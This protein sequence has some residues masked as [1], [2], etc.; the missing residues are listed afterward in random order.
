MSIFCSVKRAAVYS[1]AAL[2]LW[3]AGTL[4]QAEVQES[5]DYLYYEIADPAETGKSLKH[6]LD[7]ATPV[8]KQGVKRHGETRWLM[9][10]HTWTEMDEGSCKISRVKVDLN[11]TVL[12]PEMVS[13]K[14]EVQQTFNR[15]VEV[16]QEHLL[17]HYMVAIKAA[18]QIELDITNLPPAADCDSLEQQADALANAIVK[19]TR[20]TE[21]GLDDMTDYG[22]KQ[23]VV[24]EDGE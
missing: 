18:N 22:A 10:W 23:G 3:G 21:Q 15:Y 8:V 14:P 7:A 2:P 12:L 1:L 13:K 19:E 24:L 6:S 11:A 20:V 5:I 9:R 16:L 4:A 17:L